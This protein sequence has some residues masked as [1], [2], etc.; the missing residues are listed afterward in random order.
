MVGTAGFEPATPASRT[1]CSAKLSH[2]PTG[3][4]KDSIATRLVKRG[5][6]VFE[7]LTMGTKMGSSTSNDFADNRSTASRTGLSLLVVNLVVVLKG[8]CPALTIDI[9]SYT[10]APGGDS[11]FKHLPDSLKK[12]AGLLS[13][14]GVSWSFWMD[15]SPEKG[16]ISI[17]VS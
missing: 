10:R 13:G 11:F 9:V 12:A 16:L 6:G 1:Q 2:V 8:S 3:A 15:A 7:W 17:Y 5:E 4:N 14:Q